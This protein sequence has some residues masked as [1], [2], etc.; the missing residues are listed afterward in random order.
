[1]LEEFRVRRLAVQEEICCCTL[2]SR[3]MFISKSEG[4]KETKSGMTSANRWW[5]NDR[6]EIR[7]LRG[8]YGIYYGKSLKTQHG[9]N[10]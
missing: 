1:M 6:N 8:V 10:S 7:V 4:E 3:L 2:W 5:F 9:N